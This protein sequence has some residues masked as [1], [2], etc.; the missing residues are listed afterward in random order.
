MLTS[1]DVRPDDMVFIGD[2]WR[3]DIAPALSLGIHTVWVSPNDDLPPD[4]RRPDLIV[5]HVSDL[6]NLVS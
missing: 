6:I 5:Q 4:D 1:L 3:R 2:S